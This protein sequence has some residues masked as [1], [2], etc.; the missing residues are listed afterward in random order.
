[1]EEG[2]TANEKEMTLHEHRRP[3]SYTITYDMGDN[4]IPQPA[5]A[6]TSYTVES[7]DYQP[8]EPDCLSDDVMFQGWQLDDSPLPIIRHGS[9]GNRTFRA[10]WNYADV[11]VQ[12]MNGQT[13]VAYMRVPNK[14]LLK[15]CENIEIPALQKRGYNLEG[16]WTSLDE[17]GE[18]L[19]DDLNYLI[20]GPVTFHAKWVPAEYEIRYDMNDQGQ[21]P[22]T[23]KTRYTIE[24]TPYV[25]PEAETVRGYDFRGWEPAAIP[26][27]NIGNFNFSA[28]WVLSR[29][30]ISYLMNGVGQPPENAKSYY[31][32]YDDQ[33]APGPVEAYGYRFL[34]WEPE[35][36]VVAEDSELKPIAFSAKWKANTYTLRFVFGDGEELATQQ[37]YGDTIELPD[38]DAY[39]PEGHH[40]E[41]WF[42]G[43]NQGQKLAENAI[44]TGDATYYAHWTPNICTITFY[45][46]NG[47]G[48]METMTKSYGQALDV[49]PSFDPS[50]EDLPGT[51]MDGWWTD[52]TD[53]EEITSGHVVRGD[54]HLYAHW[55][56]KILYKGVGGTMIDQL[57]GI[58]G[59]FSQDRYVVTEQE[60]DFRGDWSIVV[61]F[62]T[63]NDVTTNQEVFGL[64]KLDSNMEFGVTDNH[65]M[66]ELVDASTVQMGTLDCH[67]NTSYKVKVEKA[68]ENVNCYVWTDDGWTLDYSGTSSKQYVSAIAFGMDVDA[69]AE[70]WRGTID[71]QNSHMSIGGRKFVFSPALVTATFDSRGGSSVEPVRVVKGTRLSIIPE[72]TRNGYNFTGWLTPPDYANELDTTH[73]MESNERF[74]ARWEAQTYEISYEFD[75]GSFGATPYP[76]SYT[77]ETETFSIP[78]PEKEEHH[79]Q[80]W[81]WSGHDQPET[82]AT[83]QRGTYGDLVFT[84]HWELNTYTITFIAEGKGSLADG[85]RQVQLTYPYGQTL[86]DLPETIVNDTDWGEI[87]FNAWLDEDGN[88]ISPETTVTRNATYTAQW[89]GIVRYKPVGDE[90]TLTDDDGNDCVVLRDGV[91]PAT[92][93]ASGF[94]ADNYIVSEQTLEFNKDFDLVIKATTGA[95]MTRNAGLFGANS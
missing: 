79:F 74:I 10:L 37:D 66:W 49:L 57:S 42:F 21:V 29:Y 40:L 92:C 31:T 8:M 11:T 34:G 17:N 24:E 56:T 6:W 52:P 39:A 13:R 3:I 86:G 48:Q 73:L 71:L 15:D 68:G 45:S 69:T 9:T 88:E 43:D 83:V 28:S 46:N 12:F 30:Q 81:T 64:S 75:G 35:M 76:T 54:I 77:V 78:L 53:G 7:P 2:A 25:P 58:A 20:N 93:H 95:D 70:Y 5:G 87:L 55:K 19:P 85:S 60:L 90:V 4:G 33:Y 65:F 50:E 27:G 61:S 16:W 67:A 23:A 14:S 22:V 80:G 72:T 51:L 47:T 38:S 63:G 18:R 36:L 1:M 91:E 26:A 44:V 62:R 59:N 84:A 82:V 41:G 32:I 94:Q 89:L